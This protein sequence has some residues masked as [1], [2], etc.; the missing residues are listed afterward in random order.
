MRDPHKPP[1]RRPTAW[2]LRLPRKR[3]GDL[4]S[5]FH[6][7][8]FFIGFVLFPLWWLASLWRIPSTR[9]LGGEERG[10]KA[11]MVDDPQ[12]EHG[13]FALSFLISKASLTCNVDA[14]TWRWRCRVMAVISIFTYVPFIILV[15]IF[16]SR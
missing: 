5:P 4:G 1:P 6:A 14:K 2:A 15:A 9:R 8:A 3:E 12:I 7:W 11:M 13:A 16:G 10:E